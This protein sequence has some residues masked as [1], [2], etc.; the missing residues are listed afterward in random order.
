[1]PGVEK[2]KAYAIAEKIHKGIGRKKF[3]INK[4][5]IS[6]TCSFG[7]ESICNEDYC[8]SIA[9]LI[10]LADRKLYKAK[11]RGRNMVI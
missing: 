6:V 8:I 3:V 5:M 2:E 11:N 10:N 1:L 9:E 7:V 4:Q